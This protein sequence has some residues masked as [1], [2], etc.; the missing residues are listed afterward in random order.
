MYDL[1]R[2]NGVCSDVGAT[3]IL[4][5]NECRSAISNIPRAS[6]FGRYEYTSKWPKGCYLHSKY[7]EVYWNNH[8][9]GSHNTAARQVCIAKPGV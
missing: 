1:S 8:G 3:T 7:G 5:E 6:K 2:A 4:T 9:T